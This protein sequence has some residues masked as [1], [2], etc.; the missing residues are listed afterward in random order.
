LSSNNL[1]VIFYSP[2]NHLN[3]HGLFGYF[4]RAGTMR[5]AIILT[6]F[7]NLFVRVFKIADVTSKKIDP[8]ARNYFHHKNLRL[9]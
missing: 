7:R 6:L 8:S 4:Q 1:L 9:I 2:L 3:L 5:P